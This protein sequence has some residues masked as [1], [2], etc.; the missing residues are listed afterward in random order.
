VLSPVL[1]ISAASERTYRTPSSSV[2]LPLPSITDAKA[3]VELSVVVPA[4]NEKARIGIMLDE[5]IGYLEE[6]ELEDAT[7]RRLP[8]GIERGS[9]EMLIVDD[10]SKDGTADVA[11]ELAR[12]LEQ[13]WSKGGRNLRGSIK[14][15]TLVRNRGKGGSVRHV[16]R[17]MRGGRPELIRS[18]RAC[19]M[20]LERG[21]CLQTQMERPT[22][23]MSRCCR[24]RWTRSS[25]LKTCQ[26]QNTTTEV[27]ECAWGAERTWSGQK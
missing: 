17:T 20:H 26:N 21:S 14:V 18:R 13:K 22:F 16:S 19:C 15:V 7:I 9:Y 4:Y 25:R 6:R 27:M 5:A 3:T 11:L 23:P 1:P 24:R 12:G 2:P 10:G 8:A